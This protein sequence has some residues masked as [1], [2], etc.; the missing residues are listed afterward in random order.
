MLSSCCKSL[1]SECTLFS[2]VLNAIPLETAGTTFVLTLFCIVLVNILRLLQ[3]V[4]VH[5]EIS[6]V[7]TCLFNET[8]VRVLECFDTIVS[9]VS[10]FITKIII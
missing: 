7:T 3:S 1:L 8:V 2:G 9:L 4:F 5:V 10:G 6:E